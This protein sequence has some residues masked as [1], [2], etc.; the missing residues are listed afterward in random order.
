[1][2][3]CFC[4]YLWLFADKLR[5]IQA[6]ASGRDDVE[7]GPGKCDGCNVVFGSNNSALVIENSFWISAADSSFYFYP[8][9]LANGT[10]PLPAN[11]GQRPS[12]ILR[13]NTHGKKYV[14]FFFVFF[15]VI[16]VV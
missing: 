16:Q 12:V 15:V 8:L 7:L 11:R 6:Q 9:Y 4:V 14:T 2:L 3:V 13:G 10:A 1:M 5:N